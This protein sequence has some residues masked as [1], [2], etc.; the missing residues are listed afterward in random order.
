MPL[1]KKRKKREKKKGRRAPDAAPAATERAPEPAASGGFLSRMRGGVQNVAGTG[2]KKR[3]SW[4]SRIITIA[5]L[6]AAAY[7]VARR[8]GIIR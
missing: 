4:L 8:L 3:E 6:A 2:G 1:S 7:F 5:L